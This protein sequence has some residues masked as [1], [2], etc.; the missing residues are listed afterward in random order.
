MK[1]RTATR[2]GFTLI[3]LLVVIAIIGVL[4]A[5]LLPA[6]QQAREAARR[7]QCKNNLKQLSLAML[8]YADTFGRLPSGSRHGRWGGE[9]N[10]QPNFYRWSVWAMLTPFLEKTEV[11]DS[12]NF[13]FPLYWSVTSVSAPNSTAVARKVSTFLCPSDRGEAVAKVFGFPEFDFGPVNYAACTGSGT[14]ENGSPYDTDGAFFIN[15]AVRLSEFIDGTSKTAAFSESLLGMPAA[16]AGQPQNPRFVYGVVF[17]AP[18]TV[19]GCAAP[20]GWNVSDQRGFSWVNGE[21]RCGM[22]NHFYPPNHL[23]HDCM[24]IW[25]LPGDRQFTSWG[26]R[27][28]RS[29]HGDGVHVAAVDGSVHYVSDSVDPAIW[30]GL[31]T[32]KGNEPDSNF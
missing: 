25:F 6:V 31:S 30:Q 22:Y 26:W 13:N 19:A 5:L 11:Y 20:Q 3:E 15:S 12:I 21:Y 8:N 14:V 17:N 10:L 24:G 23:L 16:P 2:L 7:T 18:L 29:L 9:P 27:A 32:R 1:S 28:A 4:I